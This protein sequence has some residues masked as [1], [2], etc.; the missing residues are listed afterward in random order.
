MTTTEEQMRDA[1]YAI[2]GMQVLDSSDFRELLAIC[3]AIARIT[4]ALDRK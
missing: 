4:L 3:I 1:L 2:A